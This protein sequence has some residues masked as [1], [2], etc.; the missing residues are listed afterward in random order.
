[1]NLLPV[2]PACRL[3]ARQP[4]ERWLIESLWAHEAVGIVGGEPKSCLC[5]ARHKHD[6]AASMVMPRGA[7]LAAT[8]PATAL[9]GP[10]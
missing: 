2:E 10:D 5:R 3:N 6:H 1:M 8:R 7:G 4:E 9:L